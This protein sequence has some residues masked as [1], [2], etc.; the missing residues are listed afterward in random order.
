MI[1]LLAAAVLALG[2]QEDERPQRAPLQCDAGPLHRDFG[3]DD[4]LVY[5]CEDR[6]TLVIVSA[7]GSPAMPF[8]FTVQTGEHP[9]LVGEGTGDRAATKRAFDALSVLTNA[10]FEQLS[11]EAH[12][13]P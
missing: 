1:G 6:K 5:G 7:T 12:R 3:G 2:A 10:D 9:V 8:V 13:A 11:A 4:W